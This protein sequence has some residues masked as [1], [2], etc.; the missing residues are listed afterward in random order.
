M[1]LRFFSH[2]M[3]RMGLYCLLLVLRYFFLFVVEVRVVFIGVLTFLVKQAN[4]FH[5]WVY[6]LFISMV[7]G[8]TSVS[9][10]G[11]STMSSIYSRTLVSFMFCSRTGHIQLFLLAVD[12]VIHN[13]SFYHFTNIVFL[14]ESL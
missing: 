6:Q 1:L 8:I 3:T 13:N 5:F 4:N 12:F 14:R 9:T 2:S 10:I 11:P 7:Y